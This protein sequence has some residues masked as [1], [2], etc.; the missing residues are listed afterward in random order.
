MPVA[1]GPASKHLCVGVYAGGELGIEGAVFVPLLSRDQHA[2][3]TCLSGRACTLL[4][5]G[6]RLERK[7]DIEFLLQGVVLDHGALS[8]SC[9]VSGGSRGMLKDHG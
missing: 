5:D 4:G 1:E 6:S 2:T 3:G 8:C 9:L 7:E